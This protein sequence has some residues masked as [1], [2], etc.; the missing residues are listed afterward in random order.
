MTQLEDSKII[1]LFFERSEQAI[2]ELDRKYGS[3]VKKTAANIL[4]DRLDAEECVNDTY[5][6]VWNSI[7]PQR[8]DSLV[9]YVCRIS[10]NLA[11]NR[12]HANKAEKRNSEYDLVLDEMEEFIPSGMCVE[13]EYEAKELASAINR[14]LSTLSRDDR[15]LF[16]RRYWYSDSVA[17]LA[18][19][20][21]SSANRISV[22]L[23]R[24]R[25]KLRKALM[26]EG[27]LHEPGTVV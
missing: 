3:A 15:V 8:P 6:R 13:T 9:G 14:F 19:M 20:L 26:K 24:I 18:V 17:D 22:R 11:V 10:R 4:N 27:F 5:L 2:E 25:E 7:P 23:F 21:G 12:Y 16:V 1:D